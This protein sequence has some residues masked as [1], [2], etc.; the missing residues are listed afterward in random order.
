MANV[1]RDKTRKGL[2]RQGPLKVFSEDN[3]AKWKQIQKTNV[4]SHL[5]FQMIA[6]LPLREETPGRRKQGI[7]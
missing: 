5:L 7:G 2:E 6:R 3:L 4:T 1:I